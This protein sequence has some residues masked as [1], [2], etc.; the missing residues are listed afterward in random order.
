MRVVTWNILACSWLDSTSYPSIPTRDLSAVIRYQ[1]VLATLR[2]LQGDIVL[3]QEVDTQILNL[4]TDDYQIYYT[5]H[6]S[7]LWKDWRVTNNDPSCHSAQTGNAILVHPD[8]TI[9]SSR[10]IQLSAD[11]NHTPIVQVQGYYFSSVH[12]E[13]NDSPTQLQQIQTLL[14]ILPEKGVI[15]G[16][17]FNTTPSFAVHR[18]LNQ[19]GFHRLT[20]LEA[21]HPFLD[22]TPPFTLDHIYVSSDL[23]GCCAKI[24]TQPTVTET[25]LRTGSDHF[26]VSIQLNL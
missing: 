5:P 24:L 2:Q 9:T 11:G 10:S 12:L 17:D 1:R 26:P 15:I 3:L 8:Y 18:Y 4:L 22:D 16:G 19:Y 23:E 25:M 20:T 14:D 21:T 7:G 13:P 6:S